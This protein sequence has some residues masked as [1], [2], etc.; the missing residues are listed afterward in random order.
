MNRHFLI[1]IS[2]SWVPQNETFFSFLD[3]TN[4]HIFILEVAHRCNFRYGFSWNFQRPPKWKTKWV[5][6]ICGFAK[7]IWPKLP[8]NYWE[9]L[10]LFSECG[11]RKKWNIRR[12]YSISLGFLMHANT[13][14]LSFQISQRGFSVSF[15]KHSRFHLYYL[16]SRKQ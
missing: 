13:F 5:F 4:M 3:Y 16:M 12:F 9:I 14:F 1:H 7:I 10:L 2:A 8:E 15:Y 11:C 6:L